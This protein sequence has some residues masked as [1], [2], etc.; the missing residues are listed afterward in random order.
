M[1]ISKQLQVPY[2]VEIASLCYSI[3][4]NNR[5]VV[6]L[7]G[8]D[9]INFMEIH[10]PEIDME[11][12]AAFA[13]EYLKRRQAIDIHSALRYAINPITEEHFYSPLY[14]L[15]F[16]MSEHSSDGPRFVEFKEQSMD[17]FLGAVSGLYE[18][19]KNQSKPC[20]KPVEPVSGAVGGKWSFDNGTMTL[21]DDELVMT[22]TEQTVRQMAEHFKRDFVVNGQENLKSFEN[23]IID[24]HE[25]ISLEYFLEHFEKDVEKFK[26]DGMT[27][28]GFVDLMTSYKICDKYE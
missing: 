27:F 16:D 6:V 28:E 23:G 5:S 4:L 25:Y 15:S 8:A 7:K 14:D 2:V 22:L 21:A 1:H 11:P 12:Y 17:S 20:F 26:A 19:V 13:T 3:T 24:R 9:L 10:V 18:S